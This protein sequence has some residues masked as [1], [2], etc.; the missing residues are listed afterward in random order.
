MKT[1]VLEILAACCL[2]PNGHQLVLEAMEVFF[3]PHILR[4]LLNKNLARRIALRRLFV[5]RWLWKVKLARIPQPFWNIRL[6]LS[7]L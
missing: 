4:R 7:A 3:D 6:L 2:V 5:E 1:L